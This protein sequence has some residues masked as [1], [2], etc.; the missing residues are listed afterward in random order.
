MAKLVVS[1]SGAVVDQ[2][3]LD[4]E[5]VTIG[6]DAG[7]EI[8]I[9]D[10]AVRALHAAIVSVGKD[11]IVEDLTGERGIEINGVATQ[12]R[13]L[14][15]GDVVELGAYHLR[16]IDSKAASEIEL[17]R[18]IL[19]TGVNPVAK[20]PREEGGPATPDY[21][22]VPKAR[23]TKVQFPHGHV[24]WVTGPRKGEIR[25]LDRV[26]ATFGTPDDRL[27]VITRRPRGYFVTHVEGDTYPRVNGESIGAGPRPLA[28][29][30]VI[31]VAE[32]KLRFE[33][34]SD[35]RV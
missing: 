28:H 14:Q 16:Y 30:D 20:M 25:L 1:K 7:N 19:I 24:R 8:V 5:R 10:P 23:A 17:E 9:D 22:H 32:E 11:Y 33:L 3:F 29:G 4:K 6:R 12:R 21:L 2:R 13:I 35:P 26:I 31:E 18:T 27:A 34:G 15:H